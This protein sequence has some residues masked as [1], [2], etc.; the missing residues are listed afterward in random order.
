MVRRNS[1]ELETLVEGQ[2]FVSLQGLDF[3]HNQEQLFVA[4][5]S[6]GVFLVD[7]KTKAVKSIQSDFTILGIDGLYA[8]KNSLIAVQNGLNPQRVIRL[9]LNKDLTRFVS[10]E[11]IEANNPE[12]DEPTLGVLG[13]K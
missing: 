3:T 2:P 7:L 10:F 5:Y 8:Y 12:F 9:S 11:T 1:N 6:K 4:D 13:K